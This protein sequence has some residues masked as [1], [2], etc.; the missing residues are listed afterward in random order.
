MEHVK[1]VVGKL[2]Q[3]RVLLTLVIIAIFIGS[4]MFAYNKFI[5]PK[6][7]KD[8]VDNNEFSTNGSSQGNPEAVIYYF[9]ASW[10]PVSKRVFPE[11][12][13]FVAEYE[14]KN[15]GIYTLRTRVVD[16]EKETELADKANIEGYPTVKLMY[17]NQVIE[18]D[19]NVKYETLV[20]FVN[21]SL[22]SAK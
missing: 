13:K 16:C 3:P 2:M 1:Q 9:T 7:N 6:M 12:E 11:W 19:A 4:S 20:E 17:E 15:V 5:K 21:S 10:C 14:G 18:Y 22:A 8:Y